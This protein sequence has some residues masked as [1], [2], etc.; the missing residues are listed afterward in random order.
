ML[1][2]GER[3]RFAWRMRELCRVAV[4]AI[5]VCPRRAWLECGVIEFALHALHDELLAA[6]T[7]AGVLVVGGG[8]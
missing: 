6:R 4:G 2:R 3:S 8:R 5:D 1:R 7:A